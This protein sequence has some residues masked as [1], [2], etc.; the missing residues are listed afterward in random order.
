MRSAVVPSV[1]LRAARVILCR[2][3]T[4]IRVSSIAS[5]EASTSEITTTVISTNR[6]AWESCVS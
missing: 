3:R 6:I 5:T 1:I 2:G 4:S